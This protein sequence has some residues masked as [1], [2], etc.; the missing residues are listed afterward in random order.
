MLPSMLPIVLEPID[1]IQRGIKWMVYVPRL[2]N[3]D[4]SN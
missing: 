3:V 2:V 4:R 1:T